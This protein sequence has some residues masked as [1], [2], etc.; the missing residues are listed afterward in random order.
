MLKLLFCCGHRFGEIE[1]AANF[2]LQ[3]NKKNGHLNQPR[4]K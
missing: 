2:R 3:I 1:I 4:L